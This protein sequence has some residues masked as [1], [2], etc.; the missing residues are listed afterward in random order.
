[1]EAILQ[2]KIP[3]TD[4]RAAYLSQR[5]ALEQ[6]FR[7]VMERGWYILGQEC[8]AFE[9]EFSAYLGTQMGTMGVGSGTDAL[10]VAFRVLG[11][12][13]GDGVIT[14]SH[15]AVATVAAIE[16]AGATPILVDVDRGS[17]TMHPERLKEVLALARDGKLQGAQGLRIKAIVPV[18]LYGHPADMPAIMGIAESNGLRVIEDSCQAHGAEISGRKVGT[19]GDFAAFSFYPTKNLGAF[20][21]GGALVS[22]RG[23]L[24]AKAERMRQYGWRER[25][26][27]ET[28][29]FNSRLD[30]LQAA[31]LRVRLSRLDEDNAWRR[32]LATL[33]GEGLQDAMVSLPTETFGRHVFHQYV[34]RSDR[35]DQLKSYLEDHGVMTAIHYPLPV[36]LQPAYIGRLPS[37]PLPE[38]EVLCQQILSLPMYPGLSEE[39]V[40]KVC[41]LIRIWAQYKASISSTAAS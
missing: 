6:A 26:I 13:P 19:W 39:D 18:H 23:E 3:Q 32:R 38:T 27:S 11:I 20:G 15:T 17:M 22:S 2:G 25:Y 4:P 33:Y 7:T 8:K 37:G 28:S 9:E 40:E 31:F 35:R 30:E 34:V 21:D 24:L 10:H 5:Q 16:L 41:S 1:M 29:G 36:H 12:G 14:V